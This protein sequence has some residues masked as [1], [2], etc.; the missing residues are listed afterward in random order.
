MI[1]KIF[2]FLIIFICILSIASCHKEDDDKIN[3][4]TTIF[5]E[6]DWVK[7]IITDSSN[8]D[9]SLLMDKNIDLH[10][11][12]P[13][14]ADI[15]KI[16]ES[17]L[18]IYVGG[19]S[20][21]WVDGVL[22]SCSNKNIITINL[23]EV[24]GESAK[25]EEAVEGMQD[26]EHE[27]EHEDEHE[28][29]EEYDEH[30]WLSLKNAHLFVEVIKE[31]IIKLDP[32]NKDKYEANAQNYLDKLDALDVRYQEMVD[33]AN[34]DTLLFGDRF[35]FRYLVDDYG[36]KY[37][38]A[39]SGCS[40]EA[41]ASFETIIFLSKKVDELNLK[42]ILALENSNLETAYAIKNNTKNKNQYILKVNS[43]QSSVASTDS[44][45]SIMEANLAIFME[46]LN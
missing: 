26:A 27:H 29:E 38:A 30:V 6:Y 4:V 13:N 39:F 20:D 43:L 22:E 35:P 1:K 7:Q 36:L 19:E 15:K 5:P 28:H 12:S 8:I 31:E 32:E 45:L 10:S 21:S 23:L 16:N 24:L 14:F 37:Y 34:F 9:V 46:A 2:R 11:F 25:L 40:S 17:D 18:F 44:Y 3:I 42:V 41:N 33:N